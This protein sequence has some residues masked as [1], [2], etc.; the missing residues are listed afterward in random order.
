MTFDKNLINNPSKGMLRLQEIMRAL[1][2]PEGG[3][4]WDIEQNFSS[5][6]PYTVEEAYEVADAIER[7]NWDDLKNELGDLLLQT[8]YHTQMAEEEN[9]FNFNDVVNQIS[10]KMIK[11]HPHVF[12]SL[13]QNKTSDQQIKD[14]EAIKADERVKKNQTGI[15]DDVALNLPALVRSLKLQKRAARVGFD[16]PTVSKVLQKIEEETKELVEAKEFES[17]ER[18]NEEFGDLMFSIVNLGRHLKVDPEEA[19]KKTNIKFITRFQFIEDEIKSEGR[20]LEDT[21][22]EEMEKLWQRAKNTGS[23]NRTS[24]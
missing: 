10:E 4:P 21:S 2:D 17:Q 3:C 24:N 5:I 14:W 9:L 1:R 13:K 7:E 6:A 20:D 18:I 22:L 16:W 19:L 23:S 8:V 15:L 11:R 12:G